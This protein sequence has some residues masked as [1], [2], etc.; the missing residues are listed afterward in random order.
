[1]IENIKPLTTVA[2]RENISGFIL[3][4]MIENIKPLTTVATREIYLVLSY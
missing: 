2:T 3:L 1:M 4:D